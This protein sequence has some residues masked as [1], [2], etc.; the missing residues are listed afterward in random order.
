MRSCEGGK[1]WGPHPLSARLL[2]AELLPLT[3]PGCAGPRTGEKLGATRPA[4]AP[5]PERCLEGGKKRQD[6]GGFSIQQKQLM[7]KGQVCSALGKEAV[8]DAGLS[9]LSSPR[10]LH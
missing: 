5:V 1:A 10:E 6:R 2:R 9:S 7:V 4:K 8:R 3:V